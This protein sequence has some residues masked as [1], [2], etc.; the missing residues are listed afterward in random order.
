MKSYI[1][2]HED[3]GIYL[4]IYLGNHLFSSSPIALSCKAIRFGTETDIH[5]FF[6]KALP[7]MS[8]EISAIAIET[9]S[10]DNYVNV[11]DI[12]KSGH[13]KHTENMIDNLP[14]LTYTFH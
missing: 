10:T 11:I 1:A 4:G 6:G 12:I 14:M 9:N 2:F 7:K 3:R 13:T 5:A 8:A